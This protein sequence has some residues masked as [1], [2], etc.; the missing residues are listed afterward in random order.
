MRA[1]EAL[2]GPWTAYRTVV[3]MPPTNPQ[4]IVAIASH[5]IT[6]G[7]W[8]VVATDA[9]SCPRIVRET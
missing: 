4:M 6:P 3:M 7:D 2:Y 8:I 9:R 1:P 5:T